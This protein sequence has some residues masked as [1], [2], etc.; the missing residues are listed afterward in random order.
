ML[1]EKQK[2]I[3]KAA[4]QSDAQKR[5]YKKPKSPADPPKKKKNVSE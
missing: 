5:G 4:A 3:I 2:A 1:T